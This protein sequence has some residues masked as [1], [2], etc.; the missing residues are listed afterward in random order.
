M[1]NP[2]GFSLFFDDVVSFLVF[3]MSQFLTQFPLLYIFPKLL[4]AV[5]LPHLQVLDSQFACMELE[6]MCRR[7]QWTGGGRSFR[8]DEN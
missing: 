2:P 5:C 3:K 6:G 4:H 1:S 8:N 7:R